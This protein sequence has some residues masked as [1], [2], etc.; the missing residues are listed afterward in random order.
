MKNIAIIAG[1]GN[2]ERMGNIDKVFLKINEKPI[3]TYSISCFEKSYLVDEIILVV[4][5][6]KINDVRQLTDDYNFKKVKEIV[7]GGKTRQESVYNGLKKIK[8]AG[9]VVVHDAARPFIDE[10]TIEDCI[11][12]AEEYKAAIVAFP[13][14]DTVKRG[15][16]FVEKTIDRNNLY[17]TQTPQAFEYKILKK[18]YE[19]AKNNNFNGT[20]DSSLVERIGQKVKIIPG[21]IKNIKITTPEDIYFAENLIK[22]Q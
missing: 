18:A 5:E 19:N 7:S 12:N 15:Y 10:K 16:D 17:L 21:S 9:I 20:D 3:L 14:K 1:A 11:K 8:S 13:I 2:G 4:K 6:N 22:K